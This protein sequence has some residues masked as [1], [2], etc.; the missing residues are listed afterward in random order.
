MPA[1]QVPSLEDEARAGVPGGRAR[2]SSASSAARTASS[3]SSAARTARCVCG[4][5]TL[6]PSSTR[7]SLFTTQNASC[8]LLPSF[9][10]PTEQRS[11]SCECC[12]QGLPFY[13]PKTAPCVRV[14]LGPPCEL[15][16]CGASRRFWTSFG[17]LRP[18]LLAR[19]RGLVRPSAA[20]CSALSRPPHSA[21][22][23]SRVSSSLPNQGH[24]SA[25]QLSGRPPTAR[26]GRPWLE[27]RA[28]RRARAAEERVVQR[29]ALAERWERREQRALLHW[30]ALEWEPASGAGAARR[31]GVAAALAPGREAARVVLWSRAAGPPRGSA[32]VAQWRGAPPQQ[33][34][35]ARGSLY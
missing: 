29:R 20:P 34:G 25:K 32:G 11:V 2:A 18:A 15:C 10:G 13:I 24:R 5:L 30:G 14:Q 27:R 33:R 26:A 16:A 3:A 12:R 22:P 6:N 8:T 28:A 1:G 9:L 35:E 23:P 4:L 7:N 31:G 21:S 17:G 19:A